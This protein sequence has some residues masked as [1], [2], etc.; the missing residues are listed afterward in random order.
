MATSTAARFLQRIRVDRLF[1][2]YSYDLHSEVETGTV[3][4]RLAILYGDNGS[5]KTTLLRL[6]FNL[7]THIDG[8][9]H[10]SVL[11]QTPFKKLE[12]TLNGILVG[13]ERTGDRLVGDLTFYIK[14]AR[15]AEYR[16]DAK[17]DEKNTL[18]NKAKLGP[19]LRR[20]AEL[21]LGLLYVTDE[22]D[23]LSN[24]AVR[25][26]EA[27]EFQF[28]RENY[29]TRALHSIERAAPKRQTKHIDVAVTKALQNALD[30]TKEQVLSGSKQ[31][32]ADA[33]TIYTQI[34]KQLSKATKNEQESPT[35]DTASVIA[36]LEA[37]DARSREFARFGLP[38]ALNIGE[39]VEV[40]RSSHHNN[41]A[42]VRI[43]QPYVEGI[44]ARLD[45]LQE[46]QQSMADFVA[47]AN[48]FYVDKHLTFDLKEGVT[49]IANNGARLAP[50][51]LSSGEK[52]LLLLFCNA[53]ATSQNT[54]IF[55]IDEPELSLNIKW[56]RQLIR[57]LAAVTSR[58]NV[59]FVMATHSFELLSPHG[60]NVWQLKNLANE[61]KRQ[62]AEAHA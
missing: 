33:T 43:V 8:R 1:G 44:R 25:Q 26:S 30:S 2:Q 60:E 3:R 23:F 39:L 35:A 40:L 57:A 38:S 27:E 32:E 58:R 14:G 13:A 16:F 6:V 41:D 54:T 62:P 34:V 45:A 61:Q 37:H 5:G 55:M 15:G 46:V 10:K 36:T 28:L 59:Q 22:R 29:L 53:L 31:G 47:T 17:A 19:F 42:I 24:A 9:G 11:A 18:K 48:T 7:L 51:V 52:Q 56:Q 50:S 12:V 21:N 20:L 4:S 49:V